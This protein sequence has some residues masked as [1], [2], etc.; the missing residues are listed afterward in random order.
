MKRHGN[1]AKER[2]FFEISPLSCPQIK[3]LLPYTHV[4]IPSVPVDA[5]TLLFVLEE[6]HD[7]I[8]EANAAYRYWDKVKYTSP[9]GLDPRIF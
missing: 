5:K 9:S 1:L 6:Y 4:G 3:S 8:E 7:A 2:K